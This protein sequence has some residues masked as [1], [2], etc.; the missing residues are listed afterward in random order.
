MDYKFNFAGYDITELVEQ[1]CEK[2]IKDLFPNH[3]II[4]NDMGEFIELIWHENN[5]KSYFDLSITKKKLTRNLKTVFNI[6][7]NVEKYLQKR[8]IRTLND[9]KFNLRFGQYASDI[10]HLIKEKN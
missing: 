7:E 9:L 5:D 8:G 4:S 6:G 1:Y 10:L 2:T 3:K